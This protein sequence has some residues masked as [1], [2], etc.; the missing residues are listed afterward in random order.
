VG[1]VKECAD[2]DKAGAMLKARDLERRGSMKKG[3]M[4]SRFM[5]DV[6]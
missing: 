1:N 4:F 5:R 3:L 2:F 6:Y